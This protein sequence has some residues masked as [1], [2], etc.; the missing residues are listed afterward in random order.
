MSIHG[1]PDVT[2][3]VQDGLAWIT[4]TGRRA[5]TPSRA[6]RRRARVAF[7]RDWVSAQVG[8]IALPRAGDK[9]F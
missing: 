1:S 5:T 7:K 3:E 2:Y 8:V 4:I 6:H 9:A